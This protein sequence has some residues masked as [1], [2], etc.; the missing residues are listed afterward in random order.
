MHLQTGYNSPDELPN[1]NGEQYRHKLPSTA[2]NYNGR[3]A[4]KATK[5]GF[6]DVKEQLMSDYQK[7]TS[8][9]NANVA[10]RYE[11]A[12]RDPSMFSN[13]QPNPLTLHMSLLEPFNVDLHQSQVV[14]YTLSVLFHMISSRLVIFVPPSSSLPTVPQSSG[15]AGVGIDTT[16]CIPQQTHTT[17][18]YPPT[19]VSAVSPNPLICKSTMSGPGYE[20]DICSSRPLS[21]PPTLQP[22][23]ALTEN[24][25]TPSHYSSPALSGDEKVTAPPKSALPTAL[26]LRVHMSR[27]HHLVTLASYRFHRGAMP[28]FDKNQPQTN[29]LPNLIANIQLEQGLS[30]TRGIPSMTATTACTHCVR[31]WLSKHGTPNGNGYNYYSQFSH[32][33][34]FAPSVDPLV[35]E[36]PFGVHVL[37]HALLLIHRLLTSPKLVN[38][39]LPAE[40]RTP[41]RLM[42]GG[43]MAAEAHLR[44][45]QTSAK[46][47][48]IMMLGDVDTGE[49][50]S[51]KTNLQARDL[52]VRTDGGNMK[53]Q[54][55]E[56][57]PASKI[58]DLRDRTWAESI[59]SNQM[60]DQASSSLPSSLVTVARVRGQFLDLLDFDTFVSPAQYQEWL[61]ALLQ[62]NVGVNAK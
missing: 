59:K 45:W 43:L 11:S 58:Q 62:K 12:P 37:F 32:Q 50:I 19:P 36:D 23:S 28:D 13:N 2:V 44:D 40:L 48:G 46:A 35:S 14:N 22:I 17:S 24:S 5:A 34:K 27:A 33:F 39:P 55:T 47:W 49:M 9:I 25:P 1:P 26:P 7:S 53:K 30:D 31:A 20:E 60:S 54:R 57:N 41:A 21:R 61:S 10:S 15:T 3:S 38:R 18:L 29:Q 6:V 42:L 4:T 8:G 16:A 51:G 56:A 52:D